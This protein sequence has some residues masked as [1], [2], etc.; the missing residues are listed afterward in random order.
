MGPDS[1]SEQECIGNRLSISENDSVYHRRPD[2]KN[3]T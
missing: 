3:L 1:S 2:F